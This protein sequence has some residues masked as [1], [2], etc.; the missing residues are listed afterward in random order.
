MRSIVAAL[1]LVAST[2]APA[3]AQDGDPEAGEK[4]FN[5]CKACH[6]VGDK[7]Q[8][9]VGPVLNGVVG[10]TAGTYEGYRYSDINAAA[11]E[12]GLQWTPE[13]IIAYLPD[14]QAF[15]ESYLKEQ[16]KTPSGRT[17]MAYKLASEKDRK[18]VVAYLQTFSK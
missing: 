15:L 12:A 14:P 8:N 18:D 4:V 9:R 7:A 13:N 6:M 11:G 17:K 10:R 5:R 16:G 3:L 1:I 2:A